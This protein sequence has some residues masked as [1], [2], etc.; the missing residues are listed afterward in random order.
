MNIA[1]VGTGYVGLV[2]GVCFASKGHKVTCVDQK[3]D[4]V[5]QINSGISPIYE[6]GL[7]ELLKKTISNNSLN[8]TKDLD[9]TLEGADVA[10][11]A[12]GTPFKNGGIDLTY[13]RQVSEDI[14]LWIKN[15]NKYLVA[16]VKSTVIPTTTD[17]IVL[18]ILEEKSG[19]KCKEDFG[20]CMNPEFLREGNAVDDFMNPDRI[21]IG[22]MDEKS[23]LV[24]K[25][26][27]KD[28]DVPIITTSLRTAEMI[29]YTANA[30][31]ATL[32]SFSNE[33]ANVSASV[34]E[35]DIKEVMN[36]VHLDKRLTP[37][38]KGK[39]IKPEVLTYL[40]AGCGFGGSCFP[41]DV[42]AI[43]SFAKN[44]G[45]KVPLL[46]SVVSI[47]NE[48]PFKL[49]EL[50]KSVYPDLNGKK[51]AILGLAFKPDTDDIRESPAIPVI[52]AL[53]DNGAEVSACDPLVGKEFDSCIIHGK[54]KYTSTWQ[55]AVRDADAGILIT[56]WPLFNEITQGKL[57]ELMRN[58][59]IIDGRRMLNRGKFE[60]GLY[61]GIGYNPKSIQKKR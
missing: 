6:K 25:E 11:I 10:I 57:K 12:V 48:Q 29:K 23:S 22:S 50:L 18:P 21:V 1:I 40:E 42:K 8:S 43:I 33:M 55:D 7:D 39:L 61:Y 34:E 13:I 41:K 60:K 19:K 14:G 54:V 9:S 30:L 47:N 58:P 3:E 36:G 49:I 20:L 37:K 35:I 17:S 45:T 5:N 52:K 4:V 24:M 46:E 15:S 31:L 16:V 28:F 56:M 44:H 59:V 2:T 32:I 27:Y 51:I 38:V 53:L 26:L